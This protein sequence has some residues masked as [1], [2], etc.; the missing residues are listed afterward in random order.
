MGSRRVYKEFPREDMV[1]R[2]RF[3]FGA[4]CAPFAF[5]LLAHFMAANFAAQKRL[6]QPSH[7]TTRVLGISDPL[8]VPPLL[9]PNA[10]PLQSRICAPRLRFVRS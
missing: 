1:S 8:V 4:I 3:S 5:E 6:A 10:Q 7:S 2:D 9:L